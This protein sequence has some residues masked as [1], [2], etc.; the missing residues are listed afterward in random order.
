MAFGAAMDGSLDDV[1]L[2]W[3]YIRYQPEAKETQ[4]KKDKGGK[5]DQK[6]PQPSPCD[7]SEP[8]PASLGFVPNVLADQAEMLLEKAFKVASHISLS[9]FGSIDNFSERWVI[10][11]N[12][13]F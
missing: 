8:S 4:K 1:G 9:H 13:W 5:A 12:V 11:K 2:L 6:M 7:Q 10:F 3:V